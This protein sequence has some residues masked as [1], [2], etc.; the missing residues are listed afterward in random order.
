MRLID[1][2]ALEKELEKTIADYEKR[3]PDWSSNDWL[4]SGKDAAYKWGRRADGVDDA[5]EMVK[6]APTIEAEPEKHGRWIFHREEIFEPNR[7]E[8]Y[9]NRPL[10]AECSVCGFAEM[11]ASRF[12]F[13]PNCGARMDG[14][15][16]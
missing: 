3:M 12:A 13:C 2:D 14:D 9:I 7:S 16:S 5:L 10:P 8:C 4:T 11:R 15:K 6:Y 1:G